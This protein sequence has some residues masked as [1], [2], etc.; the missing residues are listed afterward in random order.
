MLHFAALLEN[1]TKNRCAGPCNSYYLD[2]L[3][4]IVLNTTPVFVPSVLDTRVCI[5]RAALKHKKCYIFMD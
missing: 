2:V 4:Q 3:S 5:L 1:T